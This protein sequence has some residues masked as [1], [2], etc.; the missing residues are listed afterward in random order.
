MVRARQLSNCREIPGGR[1]SAKVRACFLQVASIYFKVEKA[2][3]IY[4]S[5]AFNT[6][7]KR[8]NRNIIYSK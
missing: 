7:I 4:V 6:R 1:R 3:L 8:K 2:G 5:M